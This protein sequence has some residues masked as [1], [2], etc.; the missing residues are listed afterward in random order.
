MKKLL[1]SPVFALVL[2]V[3]V[4]FGTMLVSTKV[5]FGRK[6]RSVTGEF[7][8]A[9]EG[10]APS[11]AT[12]LRNFCAAAEQVALTAEQ[13]E[14]PEAGNTLRQIDD[15][16]NLLYQQT[17]DLAAVN[18]LYQELLSSTFSLENVL[19]RAELTS[20]Q[21]EA[22]AAAQHDAAAAKAAID[23]SGFNDMA[24]SFLKRYQKFP[25]VGL[26]GMVGVKM[27]CPFS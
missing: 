19:A 17:D 22:L 1:D 25:T 26:A 14:L 20:S 21:A 18:E 11:V 16:R 24:R 12:Q 23:A 5:S 2:A 10:S 6:C 7:Y 27:P 15:L 8:T 4:M 13:N 3:V 9:S